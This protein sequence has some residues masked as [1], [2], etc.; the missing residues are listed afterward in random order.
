MSKIIREEESPTVQDV[1][2]SSDRRRPWKM[3]VGALA[4]IVGF[5]VLTNPV[6]RASRL[7]VSPD[8]SM[9]KSLHPLAMP[10][11]TGW[12]RWLPM[13]LHLSFS[14]PVLSIYRTA[15]V[16]LVV[17]VAFILAIYLLALYFV[18]RRA[19]F[20]QLKFVR[21]VMLV[22]VVVVGVILILLPG[23]ASKDIFVYADYANV[24]GRHGANPYFA[25]PT[26][27]APK[28]ALTRIDDWNKVSSAYGPL[29]SVVTAGLTGLL[30][31]HP[32][33]QFYGYRCMGLV[34]HLVNIFL[35]GAILRAT[36]RSE[37]TVTFGM[38]FYAWSP[39][40]LLETVLG[41]HNDAFMAIF[42]LLG[43]LLAI[44][45]AKRDLLRPANY[46]PPMCAFSLAMLIKFTSFP[47]I[48]LFLLLLAAKALG[49]PAPLRSW[50]SFHWGA[51]IKHVVIAGLTFV[52][53]M[54]LSYGPFFVGHSLGAI[55]HSFSLPPSSYQSQNS[56]MKVAV[57]YLQDHKGESGLLLYKVMHVLSLHSLWTLIDAFGLFVCLCFCVWRVWLAPTVRTFV[58]CGL[59]MMTALLILTPWFYSWYVIWLV[60]LNA[61]LLAFPLGRWGRMLFVF[62]LAFSISALA[63]YI[64]IG[65]FRNQLLYRYLL[66]TVPPFLVV[67]VYWY[68]TFRVQQ[69][70]VQVDK[71][72]VSDAPLQKV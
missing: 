4:F 33:R 52:V 24:F 2:P 8:I 42:M 49:F 68:R 26:V 19:A 1:I 47:L 70:E 51:A 37:R 31:D 14:D 39:L 16:E 6:T 59:T 72:V 58:L 69:P 18:A 38:L 45:A 66:S 54:L 64:D 27:V 20:D 28:D 32:L 44:R 30:G 61:A 7:D 36:G 65:F 40:V 23:M 56:I 35:V 13:D 12:G 10:F 21:I 41:G 48:L 71:S 46:I 62:V 25:F 63:T 15:N 9:P 5:L 50:R 34:Y 29:W 60:C 43:V 57:L 22:S 17:V 3:I 55:A 53:I 67:M 11:L